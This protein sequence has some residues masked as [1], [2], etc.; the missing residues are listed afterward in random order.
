MLEFYQHDLSDIWD[1]DLDLHGEFGY[2]L[3][4]FGRDEGCH[5]F[6]VLVDGKY[7]GFALVDGSVKVGDHGYWM[8][9]FFVMKKYRRFGVGKALAMQVFAAL[10]GSWEVGQMESNPAAQAFWRSVIGQKTHGNYRER[11]LAEGWW[12]GRVQIFEAK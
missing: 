1:Q 3:D 5:A 2:S 10:P 6:L 4:R 9:Q 11:T 7:A 8:D 12:Q